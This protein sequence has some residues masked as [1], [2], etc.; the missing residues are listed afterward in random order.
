MKRGNIR[1]R[2]VRK[3]Q[4]EKGGKS[5]KGEKEE[6]HGERDLGVKEQIREEKKEKDINNNVFVCIMF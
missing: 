1:R 2:R 5:T 4:I 6:K 3:T